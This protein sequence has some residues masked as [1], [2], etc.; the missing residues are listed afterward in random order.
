M[1]KHWILLSAITLLVVCLITLATHGNDIQIGSHQIK[2]F[3]AGDYSIGIFSAGEFSIGIFSAGIFSVGIFSIGIFNLA[4]Y[5]I[6]IFA[7][8]WKKRLPNTFSNLREMKNSNTAKVL[9]VLVLCGYALTTSAKE[10]LKIQLD[11]GFGCPI[12][13]LSTMGSHPTIAIG[14]GGA[15]VLTNGIYIGGFGMGTSSMLS[16]E[17]N[18]TD[19]E[20]NVEYGGLWLGYEKRLNNRYKLSTSFKTGFGQAQLV[21]A[22]EHLLYYDKIMV[23]TPELTIS[24][25]ING[26]MAIDLGLFYNV[27]TGIDLEKYQD[28]D[29]SSIG[30]SLMLKIGGGNF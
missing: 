23:L 28:S 25:K 21:K 14:G 29:F 3:S 16:V 2:L 1:K 22:S 30:L 5:A 9:M 6:G 11:G 17:S 10:P 13:N 8:A 26:F 20:L 19:Y 4:L 12:I 24:R 15:M 7:Y 18:V 27:F